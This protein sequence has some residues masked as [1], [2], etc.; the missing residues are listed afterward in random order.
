[1]N[2]DP[3]GIRFGT[4]C[5]FM[6]GGDAGL[7]EESDVLHSQVGVGGHQFLD[8]AAV[9]LRGEA[10]DFEDTA[11]GLFLVG[12]RARLNLVAMTHG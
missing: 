4:V 11:L 3:G 8:F 12:S 7:Q 6:G 10:G 2:L 9:P 5:L 1:M